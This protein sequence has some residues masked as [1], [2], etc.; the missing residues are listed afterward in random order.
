MAHG[1]PPISE[2]RVPVAQTLATVAH[3]PYVPP[4]KSP[5]EMTMRAL[6]LGSVL[7]IVFAASSVYLAIK[8]GLTVSA[9]IP[10]AVLSI[11]IF[12]ALG[13]SSILENTI[14][15][16]T[17]SAGESLAFDVAA[18]LPALLL[19]GYDISLTHAFLTA[20]LGGVLG[21]LMMIPLRQG[22]IVQEHGRLPYPEGTAS[23][24]VLIVG[25][26]GGTNAR[27]VITGF[28]VGGVYKLAYSG[29]KLFRE[30]LSTPLQ[31]LKSATVSTEVSPELLGVGYIIGPRVAAITFAGGVLSYL[32][33]IPAISFFGSG[34]E[35]PLLMHN[36]QLIRDM[37][38][39]QIRNAYVLYIGAG[40][41]ATGGLISL[42]RSLPTIVGAFKRSLETLKASRGQ[43]AMPQLLRTEQDL[44]IT[45]VLGG[46]A[47]LVLAIWLAPPLEVNLISAIL[48]VIFGFFFVTVSARIT[49]EIGS[50]SNPIS[51]MVVATLLITCLVYLLMGWT[52]SED[53]FMAL[54][55]AA[56]VGIAASNG[57]TTAQDL[58]TAF[59]VGGTPRRQQLALFVGVLTS[60]MFIGLVL[61]TL[62]RGATVTIPEPHPG[63]KVTE[64]SNE[65][66]VQHTFSWAVSA[67]AL[68]ARGLDEAALRK[69]V[70]AQGYELNTQSGA[71]ELR[72]WRD[73]SSQDLG[74]VTL[75]VSSGAPI[76]VA[77]LGA[78]TDGPKRTYKEGYVRGADTPVPAGKYL[79]DESDTIQYVV[80]PGIGGRISVYEGQQLTRY[81]APKAQLF[82]LIIDGILT[83]KLPWDLVL[84]GVFIALMLELCGVSSLPFAVGVYLPISSSAPLF[85]G[86]MVR[87]FVDRI[88][89]GE[90]DFSPGTLLSSG[91]IAGGSIAGVLIAF[92]EIATDGAGTRALNLPA[93]LGNQGGL[94][95]FLN[96]V[97]ESE[98]AHP[99]WSNLWGLLFFAGLT[100]FLLRSALKGQ[101]AAM[102]PPPQKEA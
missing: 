58:K 91:F 83:Q 23:A 45:V 80:D 11:A 32:I 49:G 10:V 18:A 27:T 48:I 66:R 2:D 16:T 21:V 39:D 59:L 76:K 52:S 88:R 8:V 38:P 19:L 36:G 15:Q 24:D 89:G 54:T 86:G 78:V 37:S 28:I 82:S 57:G 56:I 14:V 62:N 87:Y 46:S 51:G 100:L 98:H 47:L 3:T 40:A 6:V 17:G 44:P 5:A 90:S 73:V 35:T 9:S 72:S 97:G 99:L 64:F 4:D 81:A 84:L 95:G 70:W 79:L 94:G 61:V 63:V 7:G 75:N 26:Q 42:I 34:L 60:A 22:L 50:S 93:L 31:G 69:A 29:M 85:V 20:A 33:L 13:N 71:M 12:R 77:D 43:G 65:T 102:S 68:A 96:M 67:D 41:V 25:E 74:A 1:S 101:S 92:L 53:R 30:V 55:T